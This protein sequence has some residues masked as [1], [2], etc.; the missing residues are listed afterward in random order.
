MRHI[1]LW[2]SLALLSGL[3]HLVASAH[4]GRELRQRADGSAGREVHLI[5][6]QLPVAAAP[7]APPPDES[8]QFEQELELQPTQFLVTPRAIVPPPPDVPTALVAKA[9]GVGRGGDALPPVA[10]DAGSVG[11]GA[12]G[13]AGA[14]T[15]AGHAIGNGLDEGSN[16][17]AA[18][19]EE[20][21]DA[22]LDVVFVVDATGSMRWVLDEVKGRIR[23]IVDTIHALVPIARFGVVAYRDLD[24]PEFVVRSQPLT[25]SAS[26]LD[27]FL[28]GLEARGGNS[29]QEAVLAGLSVAIDDSGW[30]ISARRLV[31]LVGDAGPHAGDVNDIDRLARQFAAQGGQ[32]ST[33]DVSHEA[34]PVLTE[35][36]VGRPVNRALYR[37]EP[38][39]EFQLIATA[40]AGDAATL[41]GDIRLTRR[42]I[43]LI[44]GDRFAAEMQALMETI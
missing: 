20:L 12:E 1:G 33:L 44:M 17:F 29:Q 32:I 7:P 10:G 25:F 42:L 3:V 38:M 26:K 24:D 8:L 34:N 9:G 35:A 43:V 5:L 40:G 11:S 2:L 22:G 37:N 19:V 27:R 18:Y 30:R 16:R 31:I 6:D 14:G 15:G 36:T 21:R 28:G 39:Y 13:I 4:V 41:D 23:D